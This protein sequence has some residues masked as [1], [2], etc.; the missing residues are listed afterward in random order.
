MKLGG[1]L[2]KIFMTIQ[3]YGHKWL[4]MLIYSLHYDPS[5]LN[6][7]I[8]LICKYLQWNHL[9]HKNNT[10]YPA[11]YLRFFIQLN[12]GA[13]SPRDI[14]AIFTVKLDENTKIHR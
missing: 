13:V 1:L 8:R 9:L 5:S 4:T 2:V 10:S 3:F 11:A 14:P 6:H 7:L 12:R